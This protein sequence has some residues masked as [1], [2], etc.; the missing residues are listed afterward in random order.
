MYSQFV[1]TTFY[2]CLLCF[3]HHKGCYMYFPKGMY[4]SWLVQMFNTGM[5]THIQAGNTTGKSRVAAETVELV[6]QFPRC[7]PIQGSV[8]S[9]F[10]LFEDKAL[11]L[12][13]G[14]SVVLSCSGLG[15][16]FLAL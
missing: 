5:F 1:F 6:L 8:Y 11:K 15:P 16:H 4:K 12:L 7:F 3:N 13:W 10:T 14:S 9:P 2:C